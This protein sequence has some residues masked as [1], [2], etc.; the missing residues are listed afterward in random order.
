MR[1]LA[2]LIAIVFLA[3]GCGTV[4]GSAGGGGGGVAQDNVK[5]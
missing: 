1:K 3:A 5:P 2:A 4:G